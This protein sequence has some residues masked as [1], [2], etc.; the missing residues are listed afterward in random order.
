MANHTTR[1]IDVNDEGLGAND[2]S[3]GATISADGRFAGF[4][5]Q[6]TNLAN[7]DTNHSGD[8]FV[9]GPLHP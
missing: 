7:P 1:R 2:N 4:W 8:A 5:S 6:A 3:S 9:R